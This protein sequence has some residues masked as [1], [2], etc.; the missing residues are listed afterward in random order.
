[1]QYCE[2]KLSSPETTFGSVTPLFWPGVYL[3]SCGT[4]VGI[5][6]S[7]HS[8]DGFFFS[9]LKQEGRNRSV[10]SEPSENQWVS[11][12]GKNYMKA[13]KEGKQKVTQSY[14]SV[15][16]ER[17]LLR[18]EVEIVFLAFS[19]SGDGHVP[20]KNHCTLKEQTLRSLFATFCFSS[21]PCSQ[22]KSFPEKCVW[23][24]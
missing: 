7:L 11:K 14:W 6:G 21:S 2:S 16:P 24:N 23:S 13:E 10:L 17:R 1:M 8:P 9:A 20:N 19:S 5:D 18:D 12:E 3:N 4:K 15:C 22:N